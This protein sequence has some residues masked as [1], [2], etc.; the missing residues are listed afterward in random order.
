[1]RIATLAVA[2]AACTTTSPDVDPQLEPIDIEEPTARDAPRLRGTFELSGDEQQE[3]MTGGHVFVIGHGFRSPSTAF[4]RILGNAV[5]SKQGAQ[6]LVY[7]G[8][9][10]DDIATAMDEALD[11]AATLRQRTFTRTVAVESS[12]IAID[13]PAADVLVIYAQPQASDEYLT[14]LGD[15]WSLPMDDFVRAGGTIVVLDAPSAN[16]GAAHI[17][18]SS[19]LMMLADRTTDVGAMASVTA[20]A[21]HAAS[22]VPSTFPLADSVGWAQSSATTVATSESGHVVVAHHAVY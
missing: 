22:S 18:A 12:Q 19:G 4:D 14:H 13:L 7:R 5:F 9:A 8:Y 21:D 6:L 2:L 11:R 15:E 20:P 16:A 3:E 1:M 17:V 10:P